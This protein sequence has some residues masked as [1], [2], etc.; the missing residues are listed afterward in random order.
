MIA[1]YGLSV[2][3]NNKN[4]ITTEALSAPVLATLEATGTFV[5]NAISNSCKELNLFK[6]STRLGVKK[7]LGASFQ[8]ILFVILLAPI[9]KS[10]SIWAFCAD[11]LTNLQIGKKD[12]IYRLLRREDIQWASLLRNMARNFLQKHKGMFSTMS[13][14]E[15]ALVVDDTLIQR[16]GKVEAAATHWD[17]N[18]KQAVRSHQ[19][20]G[21]GLA[22]SK[23]FLPLVLQLCTGKKKPIER[24][25][26]FK[27][28]R[29]EVAKSYQR[30]FEKDKNTLLAGMVK[31]ALRVCKF[32]PVRVK[33]LLGDSWYGTR[34]NI[35]MALDS[36]LDAIFLMKK[37]Q[38]QYRYQD[39]KMTAKMLYECLKRRMKP[40]YGNKFRA[41]K[42]TVKINLGDD[43]N[44]HWQEV[45]L[46][47]SRPSY[48]HTKDGWVVCLCT[49]TE[50][51]MEK[52]L[53]VYSLRWSVEVFFKE[54]KQ[55]L[56]WLN[57]QSADY[58]S[59]YASMHLSPIR[60]LLLLDGALR[61][62]DGP[63]SLSNLRNQQRKT[64][65]LLNYMG[66]LWELFTQL[67]FGIL[68]QMTSRFGHTTITEIKTQISQELDVFIENA[69]Q[70]DLNME[71]ALDYAEPD[72]ICA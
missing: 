29:S 18:K 30:A 32:L 71:E 2:K 43:K 27:D 45:A 51:S 59:T 60:Y 35:K 67:I 44:P 14:D 68:E 62:L 1:L 19:V 37:S 50:A 7:K 15:M 61:S 49:D 55:H 72:L 5:D 52:I 36:G 31:T 10:Q 41:V 9:I 20:Q 26:G 16:S 53:K 63:V 33:W 13:Q 47:L 4:T 40:I 48:N 3:S 23:G 11:F 66:L 39:R 24:T 38:L 58:I 34:G 28:K 42:I 54:S 21:L 56:G 6:E 57:N 64:L 46:M 12:V 69:F 25:K 8:Q 65:T 22:F 17:H 70:F